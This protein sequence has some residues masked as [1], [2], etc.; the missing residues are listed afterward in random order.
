MMRTLS[1]LR[2][3]WVWLLAGSLVCIALLIGTRFTAWFPDLPFGWLGTA[4]A[5]VI[6]ASALLINV[7]PRARSTEP[8]DVTAPVRGTWVAINSPG[9]QLPSHGTRT[10][11]Q[12]SAVDVCLP[13]DDSSPPLVKRGLLG[14]SPEEYRC[15]GEPFF[16]MGDGV[17]VAVRDSGR[18]HRA[19]NTWASF[20]WMSTIEAI[21]RELGGV[22]AVLG[23]H[24]I[25]SHGDGVFAAY[26]HVKHG[27]AAVRAGEEV[28]DGQLLGHVG[29][30]GNSSMPHLHVQLMDRGRV[31]AAAG[32][33]MRWR[34]IDADGEL[35]TQLGE[36]AKPP[37]PSAV[38]GM[39][40]NGELFTASEPA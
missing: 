11:G 1:A 12:Y 26:A 27:G 32:L 28:R 18:D 21:G 34:G 13:A 16:S 8:L 25:V 33:P 37:R 31:D 17:V 10:R 14:S 23:N 39:P 30:T 3:L 5:I 35:D 9:Q 24:I 38:A 6:G 29:N 20:I 22:N 15:F 40:R 4:L 19:R 2:P 36:Y 7:A